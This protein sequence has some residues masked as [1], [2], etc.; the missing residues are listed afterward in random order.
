MGLSSAYG[1]KDFLKSFRSPPG[2]FRDF[3]YLLMTALSRTLFEAT[4]DG[5][6]NLP[7]EGAY[8][9]AANHCSA[10]D[11]PLIAWAMPKRARENLYAVT[12]SH[13][14]DNPFARM[15]IFIATNSVR[16]DTEKDFIPALQASARVLAAG[17]A[18]YINPEG[19]WSET[20]ELMPFKAGVGLLAVELNVPV[21][22]VFIGGT[23]EILPPHSL[24]PK[25]RGKITIS[26]G[27]PV[28]PEKYR[29]LLGKEENYYVYKRLADDLRQEIISLRDKKSSL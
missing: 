1:D 17:K 15:F 19:T 2:M 29:E 11:Y 23:F 16:I 5:V 27:R 25:K 10:A 21:V 26:F 7:A 9:I 3:F 6:S 13:F 14:Y 22:P 4:I 24:F 8:I 12:T 28:R 18:I 20:G